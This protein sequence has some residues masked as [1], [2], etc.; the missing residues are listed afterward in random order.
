MEQSPQA[1]SPRRAPAGD[2]RGRSSDPPPAADRFCVYGLGAI[3]G[4]VA[5]RLQPPAARGSAP[6]RAGPRAGSGAPAGLTL[7]DTE[8]GQERIRR[9][10]CPPAT[11]RRTRP[12]GSRHHRRQDHRPARRG[13][14]ASG[15]CWARRPP[16]CSAANGVPWWFFHGPRRASRI[17]GLEAADLGGAVRAAIAPGRCDPAAWCS[18]SAAAPEPG[19]VRHAAGNR[20]IVGEPTGSAGT[21]A[22]AGSGGC[23][24]R[25]ASR[26]TKRRRSSATSGSS[27]RATGLQPHLGLHR[28]HR[29]PHPGRRAGARLRVAL[30]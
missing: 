27:C 12:A 7:V 19:V 4:L 13:A 17:C 16:C 18:L 3:G 29:R 6:W 10:P 11:T 30:R 5:A 9:L 21:R 1:T 14:R 2:A 22:R 28:R 8:D 23:C 26:S 20:L 25:P 15:P 24:A